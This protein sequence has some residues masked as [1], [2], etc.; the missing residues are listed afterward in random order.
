MSDPRD[1]VVVGVDGSAASI[2]AL[3]WAVDE[4]HRR[5]RPLRVV[6]AVA[7]DDPGIH[8]R[9]QR[10]VDDAIA[11]AVRDIEVSGFVYAGTP[12]EELCTESEH[13]DL[14]VV[15]SHG[16]GGIRGLL[17]GSV[18]AQVAAHAHCTVL[19]V[20]DGQAWARPETP[21][22]SQQPVLVGVDGSPLADLAAG[23]GFEEAASRGVPVTAV[24]VWQPPRPAW[25]I[26][27]RPLILDV[28][29]LETAE[30]WELT[31]SVAA[32]RAKY[33]HVTVQE[34][35]MPGSPGAALVSASHD[36][37]LAVVGTRGHG[38]FTG[39]LLGSASQQLLHHAGCPV[40]VVRQARGKG[41]QR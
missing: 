11:A 16:R 34:R 40:L 15:G 30:R 23:V 26:D 38:G 13:A 22:P 27:V 17:L 35:L 8:R 5:H 31:E 21:L 4:A 41:A 25:H 6:H 28:D 37:L 9:G 12:T 18:S 7:S 29:E 10:L 24:R 19:V 36:A 3:R 20:R 14:L 1:S 2:G 33:P 39:L 32:W